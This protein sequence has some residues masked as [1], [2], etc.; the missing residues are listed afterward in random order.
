MSGMQ[1]MSME[2]MGAVKGGLCNSDYGYRFCCPSS[3]ADFKK[4][5]NSYSTAKKKKYIQF[6]YECCGM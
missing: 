5:Y 2:E 1:K 6:C 4:K 3:T